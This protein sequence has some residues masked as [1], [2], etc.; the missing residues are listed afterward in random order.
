LFG[1]YI[2]DPAGV[3]N[4]FDLGLIKKEDLANRTQKF[5]EIQ[6]FQPN[7]IMLGGSRV[8]FLNTQDVKKYT[9]DKVYNLAFSSSTLEEQYYF[10]KYSIENFDIKNVVIGLNLYPFSEVLRENKNTDFDKEIFSTGFTLQKELKHYLELPMISYIK[11]YYT[12]K[13][14]QPLYKDGS[15]TAYN[16][17]LQISKKS[18]KE[19]EKG[20][21]DNYKKTYKDYLI[22]GDKGLNILK[23]MVQLCQ[24][25]NINLK[26]FTT[27]IYVSQLQILEDVNKMDIYYKWKKEVS[28]ITPYWDFM[29]INS[30]TTNSD[31][32]IDPS[33][34]KQ[35]KGYLY[36]ARLFNDN[37][38]KV[39][40]DFGVLVTKENIDEHLENLKTQIKNYD[41]E[42]VLSEN[43]N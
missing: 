1:V 19:R 30:I 34:I 37:S 5:V 10:L 21:N 41:L 28:K 11:D 16:Q 17:N 24:D 26:V 25:N 18:W 8:H 35:E 40:K 43:K 39:P 38:I 4:K 36:F 15:R 9:N 27:A 20:S 14:V 6:K 2:V 29:Y 12:N 23:K 7:T 22:W 3:N 32:Y 31:N 13:W 42:K 33:H